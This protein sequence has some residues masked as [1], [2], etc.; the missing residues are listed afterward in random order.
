MTVVFVHGIPETDVVWNGVRAELEGDGIPTVALQLPGFGIPRPAGFGATKDE[1]AAWLARTLAGIEGPIDLV[2]H[3]WG[4]GAVVGAVTMLNAPVRSWVID[5]AAA[6]HPDYVWHA[7]AQVWLTPRRGEDWMAAFVEAGPEDS[8]QPGDPAWLKQIL[9][10]MFRSPADA[11]ALKDSI[12]DTMGRSILDLYRSATPNIYA[13][14]DSGLSKPTAAP[15]LVLRATADD[16]DAPTL[17]AE[18]AARLGARTAELQGLS[19]WWMLE[20]PTA[21]AAT[22]RSFWVSLG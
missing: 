5:G 8:G 20:D 9:L 10:S 16:N 21:A 22:L 14:W 12:D 2:G 19:H 3:D 17:S 4:A 18:V 1:Y 7:M 6:C 15:G 11:A 13:S